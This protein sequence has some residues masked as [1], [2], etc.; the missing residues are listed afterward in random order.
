MIQNVN[1]VNMPISARIGRNADGK[2]RFL[3][4]RL[5]RVEGLRIVQPGGVGSVRITEVKLNGVLIDGAR[6]PRF[7]WPTLGVGGE[8]EIAIHNDGEAVV[9]TAILKLTEVR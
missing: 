4:Q 8:I 6:W 3:A 9:V 1:K 5:T 7:P 2:L